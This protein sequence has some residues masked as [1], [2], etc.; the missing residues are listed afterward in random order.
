[1]TSCPFCPGDIINDK[2]VISS[3]IGKGTFA[4]VFKAQIIRSNE[5]VAMKVI[6]R[7]S[8]KTQQHIRQLQQEIDAMTRIIH[9]SLIHMIETFLCDDYLIMVLEFCTGGDLFE[10]LALREDGIPEHLASL[11]FLQ[12]AEG[13]AF[14]H[15][16]NV[17]H[18]DIKLE[19]I[20]I[21]KFPQVVISDFGLCGFIDSTQL[22]STFCGSPTYCAPEC[23]KQQEY[24]GRLSDIWSLGVLLYTLIELHPPWDTDSVVKM[25]KQILKANY[26][27]M[28]RGSVPVKLLVSKMLRVAP[29]ERISMQEILNHEWLKIAI[30]T[31]E[32]I[33]LHENQANKI[34][35]A[36]MVQP[37]VGETSLLR[38]SNS[39]IQIGLPKLQCLPQKFS[40]PNIAPAFIEEGRRRS[41]LRQRQA[42]CIKNP[43]TKP[44]RPKKLLTPMIDMQ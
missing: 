19:N 31:L 39:K 2:Y 24:D 9:P 14:C 40:A 37:I 30:G 15:K 23:L 21:K 34:K 5:L 20:L 43:A 41:I 17:A 10:Y 7:S 25:Q 26:I 29:E 36:K 11:I 1:M 27:P 13:I 3:L 6:L 33:K 44:A 38:F 4:S 16:C 22:F 8:L 32:Y 42:I 28:K 12:I 18:R 35:Y